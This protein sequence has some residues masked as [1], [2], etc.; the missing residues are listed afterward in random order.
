MSMEKISDL[1]EESLSLLRKVRQASQIDE[2]AIISVLE[3]LST[4]THEDVKKLLDN[5][6]LYSKDTDIVKLEHPFNAPSEPNLK[7]NPATQ[8]LSEPNNN[9]ELPNNDE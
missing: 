3:V 4:E 2:N 7:V 9:E 1:P 8:P 5:V 6:W